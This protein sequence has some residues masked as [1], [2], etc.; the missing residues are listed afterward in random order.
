VNESNDLILTHTFDDWE[1]FIRTTYLRKK[2][3]L[4]RIN[5]KLS[6][7]RTDGVQSRKPSFDVKFN[8]S[9]KLQKVIFKSFLFKSFFVENLN[10]FFK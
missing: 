3:E 1:H 5:S 6:F 7:D 9:T 10:N 4:K 2:S 8:S